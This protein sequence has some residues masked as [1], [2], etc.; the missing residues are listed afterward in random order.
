MTL[1]TVTAPTKLA[2]SLVDAKEHCRIL[3]D[4]HDSRLG[5][6]IW[7]ATS[8]IETITGARLSSQ[9]VKLY[10]DGFPD[11]ALDLGVYPVTAITEV[12]YDDVDNVEQ[13]LTLN[14][15]YWESLPGMYPSL[16]PVEYW[17]VT[18]ARKPGSVRITM[19]VGYASIPHDLRHAVLLRVSEY[20]NNS[21]ESVTGSDVNETVSTVK[22]LTDM[23]RRYPV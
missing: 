11:R 18:R 19:T 9:T 13:T 1:E 12:A 16:H 17:P 15:D 14:T 5:G 22:A 21:A 8:S 4:T 7:D 3:D 20:F 6:Y 2:V 10:L 23:Y